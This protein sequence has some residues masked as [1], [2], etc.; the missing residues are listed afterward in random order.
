MP[1][2][3]LQRIYVCRDPVRPFADFWPL[4]K[5]WTCD[6]PPFAMAGPAGSTAN[7]AR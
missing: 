5:C 6:R 4:T 3:Q 7:G 2:R 1:D